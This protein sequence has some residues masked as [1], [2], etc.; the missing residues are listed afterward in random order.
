MEQ[1]LTA[2]NC[3]RYHEQLCRS[4]LSKHLVKSFA[5]TSH[6]ALV[7]WYACCC[8]GA[9]GSAGAACELEP[10]SIDEIPCPMVD[11]TATEPA[12]AAICASIPGPLE[13]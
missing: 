7:V 1:M 6:E 13:V 10:K 11:P 2:F 12:V 5:W 9:A 4:A 3:S 8:T